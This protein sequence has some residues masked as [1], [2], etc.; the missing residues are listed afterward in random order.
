MSQ[1]FVSRSRVGGLVEA[2][3]FAR[4][5]FFCAAVVAVVSADPV[6]RTLAIMLGIAFVLGGIALNAR[7]ILGWPSVQQSAA[8]PTTYEARRAA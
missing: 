2:L 4:I 1:S 5:P 6:G 7:Q 3:R 8:T